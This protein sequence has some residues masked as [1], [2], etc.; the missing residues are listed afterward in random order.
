[1]TTVPPGGSINRVAYFH[2]GDIAS[3]TDA[4]GQV[5]TYT[6]DVG[7]VLAK[8]VNP[9]SPTAWWKLNQTSGTAIPDASGTGNGVS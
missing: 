7:R 1:M 4:D 2:N 5:T 8:T 6:Y 9:G 3:T